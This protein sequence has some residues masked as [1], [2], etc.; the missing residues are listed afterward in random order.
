LVKPTT[1][2]QFALSTLNNNMDLIDAAA[3]KVDYAVGNVVDANWN[4]SASRWTRVRTGTRG[5]VVVETIL[6]LAALAIPA[7]TAAP[8]NVAG[9][10]PSGYMPLGATSIPVVGAL[11]SNAGVGQSIGIQYKSDGSFGIRSQ[12]AGFTATAGSNIYAQCVYRWD[13]V[14]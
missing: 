13:G 3:M 7:N 4:F 6:T 8:L 10:I 2:E 1:L 14:L 11:T 12:A 5:I 9:A